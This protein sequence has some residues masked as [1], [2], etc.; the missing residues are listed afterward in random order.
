MG[1]FWWTV[2]RALRQDVVLR[3]AKIT[4]RRRVGENQNLTIHML[5]DAD[6]DMVRK[7]FQAAKPLRL[8]RNKFF[9]HHDRNIREATLEMETIDKAVDAI[10]KVI[11][12]ADGPPSVYHTEIEWFAV[13]SK[14]SLEALRSVGERGQAR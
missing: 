10:S 5:D 14:I 8:V 6:E 9:A 3:I 12:W 7:A 4:D 13:K 2:F 1:L 11:W